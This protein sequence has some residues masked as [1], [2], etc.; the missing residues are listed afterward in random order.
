MSSGKPYSVED[1]K[2]LEEKVQ[3]GDRD[4]QFS[5]GQ[6]YKDSDIAR[7]VAHYQQAAD[8]G[9][10]GAQFSLA[11]HYYQDGKGYR[12]EIIKAV[13]LFEQAAAQGYVPAHIRLGAHY[14]MAGIDSDLP[15]AVIH[16]EM[17]ITKGFDLQECRD[18]LGLLY[19][20][21]AGHY[22]FG[23]HKMPRDLGK[24]V[25]LFQKADNLGYEQDQAKA[26]VE[27]IRRTMKQAWEEVFRQAEIS[28]KIGPEKQW[29]MLNEK[30]EGLNPPLNIALDEEGTT[31]LEMAM[32]RGHPYIAERLVQNGALLR[33]QKEETEEENIKR[34]TSGSGVGWEEMKAAIGR[35]R[36]L[37]YHPHRMLSG[38]LP[39]ELVDVVLEGLPPFERGPMPERRR[40]G[41]VGEASENAAS[42]QAQG[43]GA[44]VVAV[45]SAPQAVAAGS[46]EEPKEERKGEVGKPLSRLAIA[47]K[48]LKE[49]VERRRAEKASAGVSGGNSR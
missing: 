30:M 3:G 9:H 32:R 28:A 45:A 20:A 26:R 7:A 49:R 29:D 44:A 41:Q 4:A 37:A 38:Y 27:R 5:L 39:V 1:S 10:A 25:A 17:A 23:V 6:Y 33:L 8:Q 12:E 11:E 24:A 18:K 15:R 14:A 13:G 16:Y 19:Y 42:A 48:H 22:E 40:C 21:L 46:P 34:Y 2:Q 35:G 31:P 36:D 43:G 47:K